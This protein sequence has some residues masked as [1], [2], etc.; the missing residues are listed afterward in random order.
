MEKW[1]FDVSFP[2]WDRLPGT[3]PKEAD[4]EREAR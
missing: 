1:N 4:R 2:L 3:R